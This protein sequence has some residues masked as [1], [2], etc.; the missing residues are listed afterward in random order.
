MCWAAEPGVT[1]DAS[2]RS[3]SAAGIDVEPGGQDRRAEA[4]G[5]RPG[6][7]GLEHGRRAPRDVGEQLGPRLTQ[8]DEV[9]AA[10]LARP[11]HEI[12][13]ADATPRQVEDRAWQGRRVA[14]DDDRR[15]RARREE[16]VE[17]VR[18]SRAQIGAALGHERE[19][20]RERLEERARVGGRISDDRC[21]HLEA[22]HRFDGVEEKRLRELGG[23]HR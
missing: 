11:E 15:L 7:G 6:H 9:V 22:P 16:V 12:R 4:L 19:V 1:S 18:E 2:R 14:A 8:A 13:A 23:L 5:A 20:G 21:G 3:R 17:H 10:V